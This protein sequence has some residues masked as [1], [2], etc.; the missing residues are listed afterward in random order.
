MF[1][2]G[3]ER[4]VALFYVF[5]FMREAQVWIPVWVV[6]LTLEQ[7]F[8][9]AQVTAADGLFFLAVVLLEVPTGAVADRWGRSRSVALGSLAMVFA[10]IVFAFTTSFPIMLLSFGIWAVAVTLMSGADLALLYDTLK[11]LGREHEYERHAGRGEAALWIGAAAA[12]LIGGPLAA[13]T[14]VQFT[15]FCGVGVTLVSG[16]VA[17]AMVEAP[18]K[19]QEKTTGESYFR[20]LTT[21][22]RFAWND[23]PMRWLVLLGGAIGASLSAAMYLVQPLLLDRGVKVGVVFSSLQVPQLLLGAAGALFVA[24]L[25]KKVGEVTVVTGVIAVGI[26]AYSG[27]ATVPTLA[28]FAFIPLIAML[29]SAMMPLTTGYVNRRAPSDQRATILSLESLS[30]GLFIAPLGPV[31]GAVAD[32]KG[33]EWAFG[34]LGLTLSIGALIFAPLWFRAHWR[35]GDDPLVPPQAVS[36]TLGAA[37]DGP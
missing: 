8:T 9:L 7:G 36:V 10:L 6:F 2:R 13:L 25:L 4:N 15:I 5:R 34:T 12:T 14:S 3:L 24:A 28:A 27:L 31:V 11:A 22:L 16:F 1:S 23:R 26:A 20:T 32:A 18:H 33:L 29:E 21:G 17:L 37:V 35:R 19:G 30:R